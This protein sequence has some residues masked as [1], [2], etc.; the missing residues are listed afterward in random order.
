MLS[1]GRI[2]LDSWYAL[3]EAH[4]FASGTPIHSCH[5][6]KLPIQLRLAAP[7]RRALTILLS[8][9]NRPLEVLTVPDG[10][11]ALGHQIHE[12]QGAA[13]RPTS[14]RHPSVEAIST[15][16]SAGPR[17]SAKL[18]RWRLPFDPI[19]SPSLLVDDHLKVTDV[20]LSFISV[21][22]FFF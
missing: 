21:R 7:R 8:I 19:V 11:C 2:T 20:D 16:T 13:T 3:I 12:R 5:I 22:P 9:R 15:C 17:K 14:V 1:C 10:P 4:I 6:H 18:A